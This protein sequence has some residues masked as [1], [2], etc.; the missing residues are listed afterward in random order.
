MRGINKEDE[1]MKGI[2][3]SNNLITVVKHFFLI[4]NVAIDCK[5]QF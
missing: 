2:Q 4:K 1:E 3:N 5:F